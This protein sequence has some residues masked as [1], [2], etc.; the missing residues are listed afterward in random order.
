[1]HEDLCK[2][3]RSADLSATDT[4]GLGGRRHKL[5]MTLPGEL[6]CHDYCVTIALRAACPPKARRQGAEPGK[7]SPCQPGSRRSPFHSFSQPHALR[8][9][10]PA[11][12]L[13][14]A[15]SGLCPH[16][17]LGPGIPEPPQAKVPAS[18]HRHKLPAGYCVKSTPVLG[19]LHHEYRL[20]K[21]AA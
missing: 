17:A 3:V 1:M 20:E 16:S 14:L 13:L 4:N 7:W 15:A 19:G 5:N 2:L 8:W 10:G 18:V 11:R 9:T 12:Y 6:W 21:E